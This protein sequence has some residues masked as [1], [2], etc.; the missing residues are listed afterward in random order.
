MPLANLGGIPPGRKTANILPY[1]SKCLVVW[2]RSYGQARLHNSHLILNTHSF[3]QYKCMYVLWLLKTYAG[4]S[5]CVSGLIYIS[6]L[7]INTYQWKSKVF[8]W[9]LNWHWELG[10]SQWVAWKNLAKFLSHS[11]PRFLHMFARCE[12]QFI[13]WGCR[14]PEGRLGTSAI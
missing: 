12:S 1:A 3:Q 14:N 2:V 8:I 4:Y 10:L 9:K 7:N 13:A 6:A 5:K 11:W